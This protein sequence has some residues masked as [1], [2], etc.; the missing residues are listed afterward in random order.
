MSIHK[1]FGKIYTEAQGTQPSRLAVRQVCKFVSWLYDALE[2]HTAVFYVDYQPYDS[3]AEMFSDINNGFL[4]VSTQFN[5]SPFFNSEENLKFRAVHDYYNHYLTKLDFTVEGEHLAMV[6]MCDMI[7]ARF[8]RLDPDVLPFIYSEVYLQACCAEY[9]G[10]FTS[11]F[12]QKF[13]RLEAQ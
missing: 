7:E 8:S 12:V 2:S 10:G 6:D 9:L 11:E 5:D 3:A 1:H 13:V 4:L